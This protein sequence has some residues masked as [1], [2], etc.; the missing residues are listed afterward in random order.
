MVCR[1]TELHDKE[2]INIVT[3]NRLGT[4]DDVEVDTCTSQICAIVVHGRAK[5]FGFLGYEEDMVVPWK[6]IEVIGEQTVLVNITET[7][8]S[9]RS[10]RVGRWFSPR[11]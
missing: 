6:H 4:V 7:A 5:C 1:I 8:A 2:V 9:C 10:T 11:R 3:G